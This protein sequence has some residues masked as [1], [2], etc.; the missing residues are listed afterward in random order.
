M[1]RFLTLSTGHEEMKTAE[2]HI[3]KFICSCICNS[4]DQDRDLYLQKRT[5]SESSLDIKTLDRSNISYG[6]GT[7]LMQL[8]AV[9]VCGTLNICQSSLSVL[10]Q[11]VCSVLQ[12]THENTVVTVQM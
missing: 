3:K 10:P 6:Y 4:R 2:P 7:N 1:P 12:Q 9:A 5:N 11:R 8:P